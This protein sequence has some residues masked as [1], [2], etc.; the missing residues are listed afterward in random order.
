MLRFVS[1]EARLVFGYLSVCMQLHHETKCA[2]NFM[3]V[4][5]L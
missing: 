4:H 3:S 1:G 5:I 2:Y